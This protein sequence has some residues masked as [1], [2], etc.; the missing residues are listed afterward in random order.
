MD[1]RAGEQLLMALCQRSTGDVHL[2]LAELD[3]IDVMSIIALLR[4]A[5]TM[6]DG[7]Y[8]VLHNPPQAVR[9][10]LAAVGDTVGDSGVRVE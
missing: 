2:D 6:S 8:L 5:S 9:Q 3:S 1:D 7:R 4:G 10:M